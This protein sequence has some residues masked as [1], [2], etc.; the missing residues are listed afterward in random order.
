MSAPPRSATSGTFF[1]SAITSNR[2]HIFQ[3][4]QNALLFIETLQ[5]YRA[6]GLY[7]LH[8]YV[9]MPDHIH[10]L[11]TTADL[12]SALRH[13]KGGFSRR[14]ASKFPIWQQGFTDHLVLDADQ[15]HARRDYIHQNPVR[16]RLVADWKDYPYS[17]AFH[18]ENISS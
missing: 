5:H 16:A 9:V 12:S 1:V 17:S 11:L 14:I 10:L 6:Q 2:R 4:E 3:T 8:A 7:K 18:R 15:F 13:V